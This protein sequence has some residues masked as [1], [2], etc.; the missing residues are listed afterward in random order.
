MFSR[1]QHGFTIVE[2]MVTF[3]LIG[4]IAMTALPAYQIFRQKAY[5]ATSR[6]DLSNILKGLYALQA[7]PGDDVSVFLANR[8]GPENLPSP[9]EN[10]R[11]SDGVT[12]QFILKLPLFGGQD[13]IYVSTLHEKGG[14]IFRE[15]EF[16]GT[17][18]KQ[19]IPL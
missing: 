14:F 10:I 8:V 19:K 16:N 2:L 7:T 12:A 6:T 11:L 17:R 4:I 15:I 18:I 13:L 5:D 3:A 9:M 1:K